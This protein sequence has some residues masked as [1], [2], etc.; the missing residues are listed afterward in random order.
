MWSIRLPLIETGIRSGRL[1]ARVGMSLM[2]LLITVLELGIE[3][4]QAKC[5]EMFSTCYRPFI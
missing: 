5:G 4:H 1:R 3:L 2:A